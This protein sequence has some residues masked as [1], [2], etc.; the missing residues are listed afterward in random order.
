MALLAVIG[1]AHNC[2]SLTFSLRDK[3]VEYS[4][5]LGDHVSPWP[6]R[7][8]TADDAFEPREVGYRDDELCKVVT[9]RFCGLA[10]LFGLG[11]LGYGSKLNLQATAGFCPCFHLPG[12]HFGT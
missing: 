10:F 11:H 7:G 9:K 6:G 5:C 4:D 12:F 2:L 8:P 1:S 3:A